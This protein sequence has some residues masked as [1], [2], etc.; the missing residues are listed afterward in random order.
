M[1]ARGV[2]T[3]MSIIPTRAMDRVRKRGRGGGAGEVTD[4][5]PSEENRLKT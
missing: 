2:D 4:I 1:E 3:S 5:N